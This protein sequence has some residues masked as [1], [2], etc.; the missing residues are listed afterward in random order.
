MRWIMHLFDRLQR[1]EPPPPPEIDLDVLRDEMT[2]SD[3]DLAHVREVYHEGQNVL[4]GKDF[5]RQLA[6]GLS[7]RRERQFWSRQHGQ[8]K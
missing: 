6:D 3:P 2:R 8:G 4:A 7:I 1:R 5:A